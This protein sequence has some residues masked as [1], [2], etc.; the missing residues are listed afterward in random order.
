[1]FLRLIDPASRTLF[2]HTRLTKSE[3]SPLASGVGAAMAG[4]FAGAIARGRWNV[5]PG[6]LVFGVLGLTGQS[7][8]DKATASDVTSTSITRQVS[9]QKPMRNWFPLKALEDREYER[10]LQEK[11][12]RVDSEIALLGEDIQTLQHLPRYSREKESP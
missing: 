6:A 11:L 9:D 10:I 12:V 3:S 2:L 4:G 1:M 5:M 7:L 8:Y